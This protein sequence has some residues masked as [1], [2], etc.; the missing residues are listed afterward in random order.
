MCWGGRSV[1][2]DNTGAAWRQGVGRIVSSSSRKMMLDTDVVGELEELA[3]PAA[4]PTGKPAGFGRMQ[5]EA[6]RDAAHDIFGGNVRVIPLLAN[7]FHDVLEAVAGDASLHVVADEF[8]PGQSPR[9]IRTKVTPSVHG[10][11]NSLR[12]A[13]CS[14]LI[15]SR[16]T[17]KAFLPIPASGIRHSDVG[18]GDKV[19][20]IV[21]HVL[22]AL[23][24]VAVFF[25]EEVDRAIRW[26]N[27]P[28]HFGLLLHVIFQEFP[29]SLAEDHVLEVGNLGENFL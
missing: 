1:R 12:K 16:V 13:C 28:A 8:S 20:T 21:A 25:L 24:L 2:G 15:C 19:M 10:C 7:G 22:L 26:R 14:A 4:M 29:Q 5:N 11:R 6:T 3:V 9:P 23:Q 27:V 17:F 18:R